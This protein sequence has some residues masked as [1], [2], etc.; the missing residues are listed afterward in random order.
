VDLGSSSTYPGHLYQ[1]HATSTTK[2]DDDS[3]TNGD[4]DSRTN[5]DNEVARSAHIETKSSCFGL[6]VRS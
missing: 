1:L 6:G 3:R 5:E 2:D 4:D